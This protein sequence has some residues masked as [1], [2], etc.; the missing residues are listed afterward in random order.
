VGAHSPP[1]GNW[2]QE[3]D[4]RI[5]AKIA[6]SGAQYTWIGLGCPKQE[7]W[8]SRNKAKLP[9]GV[10]FAV[11]AAFPFL[12]GMVKQA[13]SWMQ[14]IGMEWLFRLAAEPRRLWKRY[15]VYN[16][17]FIYYL[18]ADRFRQGKTIKVS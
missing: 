13:P 11:G 18:I 12:S 17:L 8:V 5:I 6:A 15:A 14:K 16:T 1:F 10:Y 3:E 7:T 9:P 4:D 2:S